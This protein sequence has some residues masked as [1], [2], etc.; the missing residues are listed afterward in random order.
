MEI[1]EATQNELVLSDSLIEVAQQAEKRIE[2]IKKIKQLVL[3][4]TNEMDWVDQNGKPYLQ[5]SGAEKV[6]RLFGISWRIDPP[7]IEHEEGGHFRYIYKGYFSLGGVTIEAIGSRSSKDGFFKKYKYEGNKR[8]ELPPSEID[9]ADVQ[10]AAYTNLLGN[11]I[12]RLLGI[13]NLSYD[14]LKAAGLHIERIQ[15]IEYR[16]T[17]QPKLQPS[18]EQPQ[19]PETPKTAPNLGDKPQ[20]N[21][22]PLTSAKSPLESALETAAEASSKEYISEAQLKRFWAL[23]RQSGRT[24]EEVKE[25]LSALGIATSKEIPKAEYDKICE[26]ASKGEAK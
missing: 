10:K 15:R 6:A 22:K 18:L 5:A 24:D 25:Y 8:I 13:R 21:G 23:I 2:A 1:I 20:A 3:A 26:W 16:S 12:T 11:G 7:E 17:T 19:P 14:D 9:R 4:V